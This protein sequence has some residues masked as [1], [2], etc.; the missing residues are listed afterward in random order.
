M[1]IL[2]YHGDACIKITQ[3]GSRKERES[4]TKCSVFPYISRHCKFIFTT[5]MHIKYYSL[6]IYIYIYIYTYIYIIQ[7]EIKS[8]LKLGSACYYS[9]QNLLSSSLLSKNLKIK[10]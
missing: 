6:W 7:E 3:E 8:R 5:L 9:V 4:S 2:S 10:I 1:N